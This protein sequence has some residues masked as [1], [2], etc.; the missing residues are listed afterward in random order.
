[1]LSLMKTDA[2][3]SFSVTIRKFIIQDYDS[4]IALWKK[5][6]LPYKPRGRDARGRIEQEILGPNTVFLVAEVG[7]DLVGSVFA[8]HD[9]RKG[10]INRL[11][12]APAYRRQGIARRLVEEAES[13]LWEAGIEIVA[14]LIEDWNAGSKRFFE[15][16]G[17]S[18]FDQISYF[19]KKKHAHV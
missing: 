4:L 14:C 5:A 10:W 7:G 15:N 6:K 8:T 1:M 16:I 17:Y 19:T 3:A 2:E 18:R 13:R 11:A 9:G 12:V